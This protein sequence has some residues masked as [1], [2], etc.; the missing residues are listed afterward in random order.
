MIMSQNFGNVLS[1]RVFVI[2]ENDASDF[3]YFLYGL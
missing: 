1:K 3:F 2:Y